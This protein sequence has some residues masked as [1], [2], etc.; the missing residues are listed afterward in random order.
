M[1]IQLILRYHNIQP[2]RNFILVILGSNMSD[3]VVFFK[4]LKV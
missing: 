4:L 3:S 2:R 1:I